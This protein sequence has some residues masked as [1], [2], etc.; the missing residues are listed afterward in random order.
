MKA[1]LYG[2]S[3]SSHQVE[4]NN[5][6]NDWWQAEQIKKVPFKSGEACDQYHRFAEDFGLAKQ[7]GHTAHRLSLEW[8]RI[9]P[10]E[11]QWNYKAL[12][13]Y[14][15][16]LEELKKQGL[17]PFVTLHH[18]TNPKWFAERGGWEKSDS[19]ELFMRYVKIVAE[20]FQDLVD[21]WIPINESNVYVGKGFVQGEWPPF[22]KNKLSAWRVT[23][24]LLKAHRQAYT[25]IHRIDKHAEV[26][27]AHSI[28]Y[29]PESKLLNKLYNH[30]F[31]KKI[32]N[33]SDFIGLNYYFSSQKEWDG[34]VS[35]LNWSINPNGLKKVLLDMKMYN[36]PIY[37]TENG[38]ATNKDQ[39]RAEFIRSHLRAIEQAQ[40]EGVDVRGYF[41]W[42]LLDNFEWAEGFKPRFGLIEVDYATQE[43]RIRP[44]A[45][46]YKAIIEAA[47]K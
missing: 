40:A 2:S 17:V 41:Y 29:F 30:Y 36:K 13:H 27:S 31:L 6:H 25:L 9:E 15:V 7:L 44:S 4:G 35:A 19:V 11:G 18:F 32:N 5:V 42:A 3:T 38:I 46:V 34:P 45:L 21:F 33:Y 14:R 43:R 10:V 12:E 20:Q 47:Q 39:E 28:I 22:K 37:I 23:R 24:N 16:V 8:S 1:F 26:G